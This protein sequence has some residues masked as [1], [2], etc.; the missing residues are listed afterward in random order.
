MAHWR[1][2]LPPEVLLEVQYEDVV[3]DL[4]GQ[5]RRILAHC[6]LEWD[7]R[8]LSFHQTKRPVQTLSTIEVRQPIY[9]SSIGRWRAYEQQ[10]GPLIEALRADAGAFRLPNLEAA[11]RDWSRGLTIMVKRATTPNIPSGQP[12]TGQSGTADRSGTTL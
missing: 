2:V 12:A 9:R 10:L 6:G 5:A 11:A 3:A 4:E 7:D 1:R 8:C